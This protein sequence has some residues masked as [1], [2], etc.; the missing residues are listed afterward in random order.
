[1]LIYSVAYAW[2]WGEYLDRIQQQLGIAG[3]ISG[4]FLLIRLLPFYE[5]SRGPYKD[6]VHPY[7]PLHYS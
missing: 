4:L 6:N 7:V 5:Y 2:I 3:R 1:M